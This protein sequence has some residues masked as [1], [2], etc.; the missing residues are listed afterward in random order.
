MRYFLNKNSQDGQKNKGEFLTI[1]DKENS[2]IM[3]FPE[4]FLSSS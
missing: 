2:L 3:E 1:Y 4:Y